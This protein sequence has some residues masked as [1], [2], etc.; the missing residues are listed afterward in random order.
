MWRNATTSVSPAELLT[1]SRTVAEAVLLFR[2]RSGRLV[3]LLSIPRGVNSF[4]GFYAVSRPD[5][6]FAY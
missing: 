2:T 3:K 4:F 5:G 6:T 1:N